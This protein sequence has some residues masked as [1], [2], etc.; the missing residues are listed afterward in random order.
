MSTAHLDPVPSHLAGTRWR[1][2]QDASEVAFSVR[3]WRW[4]PTVHGR[5]GRC[6]GELELGRDGS[7]RGELRIAAESLDTGNRRRDRHLRSRGFFDCERHPLVRFAVARITREADGRMALAGD[8]EAAGRSMPLEL[9]AT[10][11]RAGDR[12]R[13]RASTTIDARSL[14]LSWTP[15]GHARTEASLTVSA[16]LGRE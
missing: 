11:E 8:L 15:V 5:F 3:R 12:L 4:L 1:L 16:V 7:G 9:A 2:D 10:A 14:G 6:E 13:I